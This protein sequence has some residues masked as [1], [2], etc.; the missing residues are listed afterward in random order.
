MD[1]KRVGEGLLMGVLSSFFIIESLKLR[2]AHDWALSPALFPLIVSSLALLLSI[3]LIIKGFK[4][5]A[6]GEEKKVYQ[7]PLVGTIVLLLAYIIALPRLGFILATIIFLLF[8]LL[9][10]G[11]RRWRFLLVYSILTPL[12][13]KIIFGYLLQVLLP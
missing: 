11:E 5:S 7:K 8:F 2:Q 13:I 4:G 6:K 10:L 1:R 3:N 9:I 12:I